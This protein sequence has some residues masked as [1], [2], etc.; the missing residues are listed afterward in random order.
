MEMVFN[1][2]R[3]MFSIPRLDGNW[4]IIVA[5]VQTRN[6]LRLYDGIFFWIIFLL[7]PLFICFQQFGGFYFLYNNIKKNG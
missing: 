2:T 4:N 1:Q 3:T 6:F 5:A 7:D